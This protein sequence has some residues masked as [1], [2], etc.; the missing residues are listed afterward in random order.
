MQENTQL[1]AFVL[2]LFLLVVLSL[3]GAS[4]AAVTVIPDVPGLHGGGYTPSL[5]QLQGTQ[6]W[7]SGNYST[8]GSVTIGGKPLAIPAKIPLAATA[9]N[10]IKAGLRATPMGIL[11][12]AALGYLANNG[13][14]PDANGNPVKTSAPP[15]A[16]LVGE[17]YPQNWPAGVCSAP[18]G[19]SASYRTGAGGT[20]TRIR[21]FGSPGDGFS[22]VDFCWDGSGS[23][24]KIV[25]DRCTY[26]GPPSYG[27]LSPTTSP[28]NDDDW[29]A[30]PDPSETLAP[31][32]PGAPYMPHG[33]PVGKPQYTSGNYPMGEPYK[34]PD[35]TTVQP[36]ASVTHNNSTTN[37][38]NNSVTISTYN[39]TTHNA[40]GTPTS[41]PTPQPTDE[42]PDE[43]EANPE[44]AGCK[45]L[46][47]YTETVPKMTVNFA[48]TPEASPLSAGCP[49]PIQV[50]GHSLSYQPA[51]DA[52]V[53]IKPV[54]LGMAA[55]MAAF[56]LIGGFRGAV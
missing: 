40:D 37:N 2:F 20:E 17:V 43:C 56:I 26:V 54:V 53:M 51:C 34:A 42:K 8:A 52:M 11:T 19:S 47:E 45:P 5:G 18:V 1:R 23:W 49:A 22:Q 32:L 14:Q 21:Q 28:L 25:P 9:G 33:A 48:F 46:G 16:I 29:N 35:G 55:V 38:Y 12:A 27:C 50:L 31:E 39:I 15:G 41:N 44:R 13:I 24:Q 3:S 36:M 7:A 30:L 6:P 4:F 10:I